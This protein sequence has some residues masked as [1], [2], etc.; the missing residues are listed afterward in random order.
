VRRRND[1]KCKCGMGV[2]VWSSGAIV[3]CGCGIMLSGNP[4][5]DDYTSPP[6][7]RGHGF[8]PL[9]AKNKGVVPSKGIK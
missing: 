6:G 3:R 2:S 1:Y 4:A 7:A 9:L 8:K 5:Q